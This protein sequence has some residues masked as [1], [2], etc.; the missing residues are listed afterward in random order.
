MVEGLST[1]LLAFSGSYPTPG[2]GRVTE[3]VDSAGSL[4][5][6]AQPRA[7]SCKLTQHLRAPHREGEVGLGTE[8]PHSGPCPA[9]Y[10]P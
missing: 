10:Q 7:L 3:W 6:P 2:S 1:C 5:R 9:T 4:V 8:D